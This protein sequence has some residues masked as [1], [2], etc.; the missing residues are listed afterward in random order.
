MIPRILTLAILAAIAVST[1]AAGQFVTERPVDT[2]PV[3]FHVGAGLDIAQPRGEFAD[4]VRVGAGLGINGRVDIGTPGILALRADLGMLEY[5]SERT[6]LPF[7]GAPRIR[8]DVNTA[9]RILTYSIGP[10]LTAPS[11]PVRPYVN[12]TIGGSRFFTESSME[13]THD[14]QNVFTTEN[15][16]DHI[17]SRA[18]AGG[19][20]IPIRASTPMMI[21]IGVRYFA[22]GSTSYLRKGSIEDRGDH[23]LI[24]PIRSETRMLVWHIGMSFGVRTQPPADQSGASRILR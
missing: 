12:A 13:G 22:N 1:P 18:V 14:D 11:G 9:N 19:V 15:F 10:Q 5:G 6:S 4:Y 21:D 24:S 23:I 2:R 20:Y 17:L 7:P 3:R 16:S 8:I